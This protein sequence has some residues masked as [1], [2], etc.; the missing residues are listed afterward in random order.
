MDLSLGKKGGKMGG[1]NSNHEKKMSFKCS[2]P[3]HKRCKGEKEKT[4]SGFFTG[5]GMWPKEE[6]P[7]LP[8]VPE[9]PKKRAGRVLV[10][11][12]GVSPGG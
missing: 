6:R 10:P 9:N 8:M 2:N 11:P 12:R 3:F 5:K 7:N 1:A 4:V